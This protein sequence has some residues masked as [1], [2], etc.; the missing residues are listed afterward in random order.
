MFKKHWIVSFL[1]ILL[2]LTSCTSP[3]SSPT[4]EPPE[5]ATEE[6]MS[7]EAPA[8]PTEPPVPTSPPEEE[9]IVIGMMTI[10]SH[11]S[12][13]AIKQ[14]A[15]D[16]LAEAGYEDGINIEIIA[17]NAEGDMATLSTIAQQFVDEQVD[18]IIATSTPALQAAYNATKDQQGPPVF[19]NGVS[20]PYAAGIANA[21]DDHPAW[22]IGNQLLDPVVET[23]ALIS[24]IRPETQSIG[25]IYNPSEANSMYLVEIARAEAERTGITLEE[26]TIANSNEVQVAAE[27]LVSRNIDAFLALSDNTLNSGFEPLVQVANDNDILLVGTSA[28]QP[29]RGAAASYGI[30]P[31]EEGLDSGGLVAQYLDGLIDIAQ[32][33]IAIQDAILLTVNP[34]AASEQG[35]EISQALI[36]EAD[37][38]IED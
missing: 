18:L 1:L 17:R 7:T 3:G 36:D 35:A 5:V 6:P 9:K 27:S 37:S 26:A 2:V 16:A 8:E 24:K 15:I 11:P 32:T 23:M 28:S 21:P 29:P 19:F 38:V 33:E 13:D 20:N 4:G 31:Y 12:L 25:L 22:V 14:G 10:V 34:K 30:D